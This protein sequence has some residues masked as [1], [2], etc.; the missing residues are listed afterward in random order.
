[1]ITLVL[2]L[3][4]LLALT[5]RALY[6]RHMLRRWQALWRCT[7]GPITVELRRHCM[8]TKFGNDSLEFPHPLEFRLLSMR[9]A[10]IPV[11]SAQSVVSLPFDADARI[12]RVAADEFDHLFAARFRAHRS[13][14]TMHALFA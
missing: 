2:V 14:T 12:D 11:W 7:T 6:V 10:G 8:L 3:L 9:V 4:T 5:A 13:T 1:M